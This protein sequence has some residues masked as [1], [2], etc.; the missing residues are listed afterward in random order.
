MTERRRV[1]FSRGE[2]ETP[3]PPLLLILLGSGGLLL[4]FPS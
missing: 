4:G 3:P 2:H 1:E